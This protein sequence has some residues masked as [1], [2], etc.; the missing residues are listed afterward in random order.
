VLRAVN[1]LNP[2]PAGKFARVLPQLRY[3]ADTRGG[4]QERAVAV[5][6]D[7]HGFVQQKWEFLRQEGMSD[8]EILESLNTA[9]GGGVVHATGL[10]ALG[11]EHS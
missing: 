1:E 7:P 10:G 3:P 11:S 8:G 2:A 4:R 9:T 6:L 5:F